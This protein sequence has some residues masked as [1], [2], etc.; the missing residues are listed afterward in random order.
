MRIN[1]SKSVKKTVA[2][3]NGFRCSFPGC[4]ST[5]IGPGAA[6]HDAMSTG[7]AAHIYSASPE[8]PRGQA[9][10]AAHDLVGIGNA[11][12]LC[13]NHARVIDANRGV[14]FPPTRLHSFK[15]A[16]EARIAFEQRGGSFKFGWLQSLVVQ[17][18][19]LF[20]SRSRL[21]FGRTT[22]VVGAN[23]SGKTALCEWLAGC[24]EIS[25]LKRWSP[26]GRNGKRTQVKYEALNPLPLDWTVRIY[27]KNNIQF[28]VNG[29]PTPRLN[30]PY[31]FIH[32]P[33]RPYLY[34]PNAD[35]ETVSAYLAKW[36]R[37]DVA[38]VHNVVRSL[39]TR[40]GHHIHNPRF[41]ERD[42]QEALLVDVDGTHPGLA[43]QDLSDTE[44]IRVVIEMAVER[45]RFEAQ[46][47]PTI[48]LVD[49]MARFDRRQFEDYAEFIAAQT[50]QF[51]AVVTAPMR[52]NFPPVPLVEG[53][54]VARL[55]GHTANVT[56]E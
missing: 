49:C 20:V 44:Q 33:E 34:R 1:F 29:F 4:D 40:G 46:R 28:D 55:R 23:A 47:Q 52:T 27:E 50:R 18:S 21:D 26:A 13:A 45:A 17:E 38:L 32:A 39:A 5:T 7:V 19:P 8:G 43:F 14:E 36:L 22:M 35:E 12:W 54:H 37:I 51:Q 16:H 31:A 24:T 2:E 11:L 3:R 48:V 25:Y 30:V 9:T 56:I 6:L 42:D 53:L 41:V 15:T 10:L